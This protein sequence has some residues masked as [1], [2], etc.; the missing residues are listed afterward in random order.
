[1]SYQKASK[2]INFRPLVDLFLIFNYIFES[3]KS[4]LPSNTLER[5][6][7]KFFAI[8]SNEIPS[9]SLRIQT[10]IAEEY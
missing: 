3:I 7:N 1:M 8:Y 4:D 6:R 5:S 2:T 9:Q 10:N